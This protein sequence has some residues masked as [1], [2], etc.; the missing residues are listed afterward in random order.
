M[1]RPEQRQFFGNA[2]VKARYEGAIATLTDLGGTCVEIDY[3]PF[4]QANE[5]LFNGAC[6]AERY[7]SVGQFIEAN[8]EAVFPI[9]RDMITQAKQL[10]AVAAFEGLYMVEQ[11][12]QT[13]APWGKPLT[14]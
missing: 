5:L 7:A 3:I 14:A 10:T 13:I 9:T 6:V 11:L 4:L 2:A 12:K 8:P 1:P